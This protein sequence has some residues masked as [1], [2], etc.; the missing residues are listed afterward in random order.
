[1]KNIDDTVVRRKA[2]YGLTRA[3]LEKLALQSRT[4]GETKALWVCWTL[5][6]FVQCKRRFPRREEMDQLISDILDRNL[7]HQ[8]FCSK[9]EIVLED[10]LMIDDP[11][12]YYQELLEKLELISQLREGWR[13][14]KDG[15]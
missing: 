1:M 7:G 12:T 6:L 3:L 15:Q 13:G 9:W 2:N 5:T 8:E 10:D 14:W 4:S 11:E